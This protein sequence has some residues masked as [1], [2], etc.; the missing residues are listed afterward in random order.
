MN[1]ICL[2]LNHKTAPV[3][4]REKLSLGDKHLGEA[5]EE[6]LGIE[7][8]QET[9]VLSTCNRMEIY[10]VAHVAG[11]A[12]TRLAGYMRE[13]F[14]LSVAESA[15]F[16]LHEGTEAARHL[17][18]VASGLDSMVLGE[19]EIFGQVKKAYHAAHGS[20]ATAKMLNKLFQRSFQVGKMVRSSTNIGQ[21]ATS[22]GSV[23]VDLAEKIFGDLKECQVMI[24]GAGEMSR[25]TAQSLLSRGARSIFV[26]NRS[27]DR[28]VELAREMEGVAIHF[29]DWLAAIPKV[30]IMITSTSAPH[31]F[32]HPEGVSEAMRLRRGR[33]LFVID[34]AVPRDVDPAVNEIE[35]VYLYDI[36][37]LEAIAAEGRGRREKQVAACERLIAEELRSWESLLSE[38]GAARAGSGRG[39]GGLTDLSPAHE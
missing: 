17:F 34:I 21:G 19:T 30:D 14:G 36:D 39:E 7:G 37:S 2:G 28:A 24:I 18:R 3:E 31:T 25:A 26:S 15:A 22:V 33:P 5:I 29:D 32:I 20:R 38:A 8:I 6:V 9:V 10:A 35:G 11:G 27:Y 13:H 1:L 23:A 16:Y 4:V 12:A